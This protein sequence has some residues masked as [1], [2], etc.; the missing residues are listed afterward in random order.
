MRLVTIRNMRVMSFGVDSGSVKGTCI[1][2][3][4]PVKTKAPVM[5]FRQEQIP[6]FSERRLY[7][8]E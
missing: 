3:N 1:T 7:G 5:R 2:F 8:A 4:K 6:R